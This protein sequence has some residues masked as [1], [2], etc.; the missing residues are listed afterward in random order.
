[1]R[2]WFGV[3]YTR[4]AKTRDLDAYRSR[5]RERDTERD[6]DWGSLGRSDRHARLLAAV[7]RDH[8][9]VHS[10]ISWPCFSLTCLSTSRS[11]MMSHAISRDHSVLMPPYTLYY[12]ALGAVTECADC[13]CLGP[14]PISVLL[15]FFAAS[16]QLF[17]R[18]QPYSIVYSPSNF[19]L[20]AAEPFCSS[21]PRSGMHCAG[22][23]ELKK[24]RFVIL[25]SPE[26]CEAS[27]KFTCHCVQQTTQL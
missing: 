22:H 23:K 25:Y 26:A 15:C 10:F 11:V 3:R 1:M 18:Y 2:L 9:L 24:L 21:P 8:A 14:I 13:M 12:N 20:S 6:G 4:R 7:S 17:C 5:A 27:K 16:D 19:Q